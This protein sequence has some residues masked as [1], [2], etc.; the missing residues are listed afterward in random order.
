MHREFGAYG[1][2]LFHAAFPG[3]LFTG[4]PQLRNDTQRRT[5]QVKNN[6]HFFGRKNILQKIKTNKLRTVNAL[7]YSEKLCNRTLYKE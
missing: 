7:S 4:W 2:Y 6:P 3:D 5:L 1:R